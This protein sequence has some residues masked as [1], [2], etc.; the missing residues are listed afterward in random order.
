MYKIAD[1]SHFKNR[2]EV[3]QSSHNLHTQEQWSHM[4]WFSTIVATPNRCTPHTACWSWICYL[5]ESYAVLVCTCIFHTLGYSLLKATCWWSNEYIMLIS[6]QQLESSYC[7]R[8]KY[9]H[10]YSDVLK[11]G[12]I[13]SFEKGMSK[14][15]ANR[16]Q[17]ECHWKWISRSW[18]SLLYM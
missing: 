12:P 9:Y 8:I 1:I 11:R 15:P 18:V 16:F 2:K 6:I 4:Q 14:V 5:F 3:V 7:K 13:E 17:E 10:E